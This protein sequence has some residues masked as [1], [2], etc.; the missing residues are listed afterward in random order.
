MSILSDIVSRNSKRI[1]K[2]QQQPQFPLKYDPAYGPY[3]PITSIEESYKRNFIN[4]LL[5]SPGEWPMSPE[6]GV[7]LKHYLFEHPN[8]EKLQSL[9]PVIHD[10]LRLHLPQVVLNDLLFDYK[11]EDIDNN[12]VKILMSYTVLGSVGITT[13]FESAFDSVKIEDIQNTRFQG[14]DLLNRREAL[15]SD[16]DML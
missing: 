3:F 16:I 13:I 15:V 7:G 12:K 5:T 10:Q 2:S 1:I 14:I 9:A 8:S 6:I 4:L 11:D